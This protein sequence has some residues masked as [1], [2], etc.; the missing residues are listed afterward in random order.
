MR[1]SR[2]LLAVLV[3]T[4]LAAAMP[5]VGQTDA[6]HP[7]LSGT[8]VLDVAKSKVTKG[9]GLKPETLVVKCVGTCIEISISSNGEKVP[10]YPTIWHADGVAGRGAVGNCYRASELAYWKQSSL[11]TERGSTEECVAG[12]A[13][14]WHRVE[15]WTLSKDGHTLTRKSL[16]FGAR[17]SLESRDQG[18][19]LVYDKQ[20]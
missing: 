4:V 19:T 18:Q 15:T 12:P 6:A 13:L 1:I 16:A 2:R 9:V 10:F 7:N 17:D 5:V 20:P 14:T 11:V 3:L 8:W